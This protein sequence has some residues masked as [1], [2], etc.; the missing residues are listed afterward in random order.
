MKHPR[1]LS[2]IILAVLAGAIASSAFADGA[3][4]SG[5]IGAGLR[6]DSG[7]S[8]ADPTAQIGAEAE[9]GLL[10]KLSL[11]LGYAYV[12]GNMTQ[13]NCLEVLAK[14]YLLGKPLDVFAGAALQLHFS[15][16]LGVSATL[17]TGA[18]WQSPFKLF[19]GAEAAVLFEQAGM[20]WMGGA[21]VGLRL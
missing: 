18:E 10:E 2:I 1:V 20:G 5:R 8:S 7:K 16:G 15:G 4:R 21:F 12:D 17:R 14:G 13:E 3:V 11:G 9:Y 6:V 19:L